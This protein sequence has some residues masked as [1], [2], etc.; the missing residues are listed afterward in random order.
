MIAEDTIVASNPNDHLRKKAE[1]FKN[2]QDNKSDF[3]KFLK[4]NFV[5]YKVSPTAS[6]SDSDINLAFLYVS[7]KEVDSSHQ[8][9]YP[10][11]KF[12]DKKVLSYFSKSLKDNQEICQ[13]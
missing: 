1:F 11:L 9:R 10:H 6:F 12:M 13:I 5:A 3:I 8:L 7:R 2:C 4:T